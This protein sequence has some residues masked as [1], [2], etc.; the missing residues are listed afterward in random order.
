M[1]MTYHLDIITATNVL[2]SGREIQ[3]T[4]RWRVMGIYPGHAPLL[5]AV[6]SAYDSHRETARSR[7]VLS[8]SGGILEVPGNV[9]VCGRHRDSPGSRRSE[10]HGSENVRLKS[11]VAALTATS[12][13]CVCGTGQSNGAAARYRVDQ[14]AM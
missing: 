7:R 12:L 10:S 11:T 3:V 13:R 4:G 9:T 6:K 1:A 14:K 8:L 2:W 5:T